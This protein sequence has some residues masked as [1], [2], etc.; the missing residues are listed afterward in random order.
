MRRLFRTAA[1]VER[2]RGRDLR[3]FHATVE[4]FAGA[5]PGGLRAAAAGF[6]DGFRLLAARVLAHGLSRDLRARGTGKRV[7]D[8]PFYS[9]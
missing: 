5:G 7:A 4:L 8:S 1:D 2:L 6:A 3:A 9:P